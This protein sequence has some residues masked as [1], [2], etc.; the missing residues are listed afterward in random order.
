MKGL[1]IK[2]LLAV[3]ALA[4][5]ALGIGLV[6]QG[7]AK[8]D[9][10]PATDPN[11]VN[12]DTHAKVAGGSVAD[13]TIECKWELPDM[14]PG[15][16]TMTYDSPYDDTP[17]Q[18]ATGPDG[19]T[20][21]PCAPGVACV[22]GRRHMMGIVPNPDD[23]DP[24]DPDVPIKRQ[25]EK[26][27]AVA[28][29]SIGTISDVYWKVWEPYEA[30]PPNGPNCG[31]GAPAPKDKIPVQT[32]PVGDP[33]VNKQFCFKY[34]HH[35]TA[36]RGPVTVSNPLGGGGTMFASIPGG[37]DNC[38]DLAAMTGMFTAAIETGQM[39]S[40][41]KTAILQKC[42]QHSKA[43]FRVQEDI[44]KEQSWGEYRVEVTVNMTGPTFTNVNFFDVV[45]FIHIR[46]DFN[47]V[48]WETMAP[49][50]FT[51]IDGDFTMETVGVAKRS[52]GGVHPTIEN[53]GNQEM[54]VKV[55]FNPLLLRS[56]NTKTIERF[57]VSLWADWQTMG[58]LETEYPVYA[59]DPWVCFEN[60]Q[61]GSNGLG[62]IDFS[63]HP[64]SSAQN[65]DYD[66]LEGIEILGVASCY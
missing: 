40:A 52:A 18:D 63:V 54:F 34:Q 45:P 7:T 14:S 33:P 15:D 48:D 13:I 21:E 25:Y 51:S 3:A 38:D 49:G 55:D 29:G 41:E 10:D 2:G 66:A 39:T 5:L 30:D 16:A 37:L 61:L 17:G 27:V 58:N 1:S 44:S 31:P 28:S 57:D 20:E 59:S 62:K 53:V 64:E 4:V 8:A 6:S 19:V 26:W 24:A 22:D 43:V 36:D 42:Y 47:F 65:G 60:N 46:K 12:V 23:A 35:A 56:D 11:C 32:F 9:C 50:A